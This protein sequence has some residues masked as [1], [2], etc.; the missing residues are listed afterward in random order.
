M[1]L[2]LTLSALAFASEKAYETGLST[3]TVQQA[4]VAGGSQSKLSFDVVAGELEVLTDDTAVGIA[5][6]QDGKEVT[7]GYVGDGQITIVV[8]NTESKSS[9]SPRIGT[10]QP[11][12]VT[13]NVLV[14]ETSSGELVAVYQA[15]ADAF[16]DE[17][18]DAVGGMTAAVA[19]VGPDAA[20]FVLVGEKDT[21]FVSVLPDGSST[22]GT[23]SEGDF[24]GTYVDPEVFDPGLSPEEIPTIPELYPDLEIVGGSVIDDEAVLAGLS[25][26]LEEQ[27]AALDELMQEIMNSN[28]H[29]LG[30]LSPSA[31]KALAEWYAETAKELFE[32]IGDINSDDDG[33]GIPLPFDND[34]DNDGIPNWEDTDMDNDGVN[35]NKDADPTDA[36]QSIMA[37]TE[38]GALGPY[39]GFFG[40]DLP[41]L[42]QVSL[43]L[44][45]E[46][47]Q[48]G[49][50][51]YDRF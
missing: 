31:W 28:N 42:R 19:V 43:E 8:D 49:L 6:Y 46:L 18:H 23:G 4:K 7:D 38:T 13:G 51:L 35:N 27:L 15:D 5:V 22:A 17:A 26:E 9:A 40:A 10:W 29:S 41:E 3:T 37:E 44:D 34:L 39:G 33:D 16:S 50:G 48:D 1:T 14:Y 24:E 20:E 30:G 45:V 25:L 36:D 2:L 11:H 12:E 47:V 21:V 32:E